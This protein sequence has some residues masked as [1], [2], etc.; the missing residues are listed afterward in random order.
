MLTKASISGLSLRGACPRLPSV[1]E[2]VLDNVWVRGHVPEVSMDQTL[3]TMNKIT[4]KFHSI[5]GPVSFG[6]VPR[7]VPPVDMAGIRVVATSNNG[8][9]K[10]FRDLKVKNHR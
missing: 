8:I 6:G 7:K 9:L 4:R 10:E 3:L 5:L 1:V 2:L